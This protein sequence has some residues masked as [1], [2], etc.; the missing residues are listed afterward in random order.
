LHSICDVP[1]DVRERNDLF[2]AISLVG[3]DMATFECSYK[4]RDASIHHLPTC[5]VFTVSRQLNG[6]FTMRW[7]ITD[8]PDSDGRNEDGIPVERRWGDVLRSLSAWARELKYNA[9]NRDLWEELKQT[10]AALTRIQQEDVADAPFTAD[11]RAE[12]AGRIKEIKQEARTNPDL[13]A[14]QVT[15]IERKLDDLVGASERVGRKD[16]LTMLYGAAFGMIVND[17]VPPHVV[18][19]IITSV[20]SGLGHLFGL[21]ATPPSALG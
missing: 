14:E 16:W 7:Q 15:G 18:Q 17:T 20:V 5:S 9:E 2:K 8:G 12:I 19:S 21:G 1:F 3:A 4:R 13:P 10:S 6:S 11:A